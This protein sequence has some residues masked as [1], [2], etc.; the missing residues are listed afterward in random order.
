MSFSILVN[1][2][3]MDSK[4]EILTFDDGSAVARMGA[5]T[6]ATSNGERM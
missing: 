5:M 1:F 4:P 3:F 2:H 6:A